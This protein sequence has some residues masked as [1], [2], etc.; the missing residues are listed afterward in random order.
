MQQQGKFENFEV[1]FAAAADE[2]GYNE[3]DAA[4]TQMKKNVG[5]LKKK[6]EDMETRKNK[7]LNK[8]KGITTRHQRVSE[9]LAKR[10]AQAKEYRKTIEAVEGGYNGLLDSS[11]TLLEVL[12]TQ[13]NASYMGEEEE[14]GEGNFGKK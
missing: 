11:K 5:M 2:G 8:V 14:V 10:Q 4:F 9:R 13:Q 6:I 1:G 7:I 3:L 12:Q